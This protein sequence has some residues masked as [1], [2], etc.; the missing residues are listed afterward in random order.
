LVLRA[1]SWRQQELVLNTTGPHCAAP[2][3][4]VIGDLQ[5]AH[6]V[7]DEPIFPGSI[8]QVSLESH[9]SRESRAMLAVSF[10]E[11]GLLQERPPC[12]LQPALTPTL[13]RLQSCSRGWMGLPLAFMAALRDI[14]PAVLY[15]PAKCTIHGSAAEQTERLCSKQPHPVP[16]T[17]RPGNMDATSRPQ[18]FAYKESGCR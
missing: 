7:C 5:G 10:E 17:S 16:R 12:M 1:I 9:Q 2:R 6:F 15:K 4:P 11:V 13:G 18:W 3:V 8:H 14:H